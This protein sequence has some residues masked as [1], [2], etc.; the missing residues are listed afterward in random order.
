[1]SVRTAPSLALVQAIAV[2]FRGMTN[3]QCEA[4]QWSQKGDCK[5]LT[6]FFVKYD[7]DGH[8]KSGV[9]MCCASANSELHWHFS[10]RRRV[11]K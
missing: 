11:S 1:V 4:T 10:S 9:A 7:A 8:F 5:V 3:K 2:Q 6:D